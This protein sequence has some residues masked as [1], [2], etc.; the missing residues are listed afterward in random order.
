MHTGYRIRGNQAAAEMDTSSLLA[1]TECEKVGAI[2]AA[3][4]GT[5]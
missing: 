5:S 3:S 4:G 2:Q 1:S